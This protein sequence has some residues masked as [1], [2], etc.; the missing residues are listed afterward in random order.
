MRGSHCLHA[1]MPSYHGCSLAFHVEPSPSHRSLEPSQTNSIVPRSN[2]YSKCRGRNSPRVG[3]RRSSPK[4][5]NPPSRTRF[6]SSPIPQGEVTVCPT[7]SPPIP[8]RRGFSSASFGIV[9]IRMDPVRLPD[10]RDALRIG[11]CPCSLFGRLESGQV[12]S[13]SN[14]IHPR[15]DGYFPRFSSSGP[16]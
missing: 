10:S 1:D 14:D 15:S 4:Q 3:Y 5:G 13:D 9:Q 12:L 2:L 6:I 8:P 16:S 11:R 7:P